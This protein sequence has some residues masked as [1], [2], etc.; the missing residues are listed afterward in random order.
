MYKSHPKILCVTPNVY[1]TTRC[2]AGVRTILLNTYYHLS[3]C[4]WS[5]LYIYSS[6][7]LLF[8]GLNVVCFV[9]III[10]CFCTNCKLQYPIIAQRSSFVIFF[11]RNERKEKAS[12]FW[13]Q[14]I[15]KVCVFHMEEADEFIRLSLLKDEAFYMRIIYRSKFVRKLHLWINHNLDGEQE[16]RV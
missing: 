15:Y 12:Q 13:P 16:E 11:I 5:D 2:G 4:V 1:N 8:F 9:R 3:A 7:M 10:P 14:L 6:L